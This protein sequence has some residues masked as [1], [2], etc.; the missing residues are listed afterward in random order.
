VR[1]IKYLQGTAS[2][3]IFKDDVATNLINIVVVK[4]EL[5]EEDCSSQVIGEAL[6]TTTLDQYKLYLIDC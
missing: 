2:R 5:S 3:Q 4:I 1:K 6:T